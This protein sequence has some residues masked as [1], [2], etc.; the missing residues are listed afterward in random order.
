MSSSLSLDDTLKNFEKSTD[1]ITDW[2]P[3]LYPLSLDAGATAN[4]I[5]DGGDNTY[6]KG[7]YIGTDSKLR[8]NYTNKQIIAGE[9]IFGTNGKYFT[10]MKN[11]IFIL[12]ATVGDGFHNFFISGNLGADGNGSVDTFELEYNGYT[13]YIKRVYGAG[14]TPSVNHIFILDSKAITENTE[15]IYSSNTDSDYQELTNIENL[16]TI[17]NNKFYYLAFALKNGGYI[18]NDD[19]R[20]VIEF[21]IDKMLSSL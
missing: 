7:N 6:N 19:M 12:N 10:M 16:A 2:I 13:I 14:S 5:Y 18:N 4:Y 9:E 15:H 11:N 17:E 8:I 21:F 3:S 20:N 1:E